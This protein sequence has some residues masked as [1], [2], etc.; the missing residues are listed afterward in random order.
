MPLAVF[1]DVLKQFRARQIPAILQNTGELAVTHDTMMADPAFST[2]IELDP[3]C[4]DLDVPILQGGQAKTVV[5]SRVFR[6]TDAR[7]GALH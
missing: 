3:P 2:K 5:L 4:P 7:E 6:I 1:I